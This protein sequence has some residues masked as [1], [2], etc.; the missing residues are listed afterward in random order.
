MEG[1]GCT[2]RPA[3]FIPSCSGLATRRCPSVPWALMK[4]EFVLDALQVTHHP[5]PAPH[6]ALEDHL[7]HLRALL[8]EDLV[9]FEDALLASV[10]G[11]LAPLPDTSQHLIAAGGKRIRPLLVLLCGRAAGNLDADKL[12]PLALAGEL[13]HVAT[14][15]HDD[16]LDDADERRH[17]PTPRLRWGNTASVLGGDYA[18]TRAL[19]CVDSVG[20]PAPMREAIATLRSLVEGE[21]LQAHLRG[22]LD[23]THDDYMQVIE[24][25][26]AS[27]FR[28][29]AR[30]GAHCGPHPSMATALGHFGGALGLAFQMIDDVIDY[31]SP[32]GTSGKLPLADLREGKMTL[33]LLLGLERDATLRPWLEQAQ[34]KLPTDGAARRE[35]IRRLQ[36]V[37]AVGSARALA[38]A[39]AEAAAAALSPLAA[40][41][42]RAALEGIAYGLAE[43]VR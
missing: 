18:L 36:E 35:L 38:R 37:D 27:L 9:G 33:P 42:Y 14:L 23:V 22:R 19:D 20:H 12:R 2:S 16:V 7:A 39:Q 41:P 3:S 15:L 40:S 5:S 21:V 25:K 6:P 28:W 8:V 34:G 13:V 30:A 24:R 43:R 32:E 29:C 17:R 4:A 31:E 1:A 10:D 11:S 26:T